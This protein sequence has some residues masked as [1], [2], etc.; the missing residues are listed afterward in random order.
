MNH[1]HCPN[2]GKFAAVAPRA[3]RRG[4]LLKEMQGDGAPSE[5]HC[6]AERTKASRRSEQRWA[7][8][9]A[10]L[11]AGVQSDKAMARLK[12]HGHG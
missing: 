10:M 2:C 12:A 6:R 7:H 5:P 1:I 8:V 9:R 4:D 3:G 11:A